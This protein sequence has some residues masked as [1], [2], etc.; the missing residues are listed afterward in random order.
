[1]T[2]K[3]SNVTCQWVPTQPTNERSKR[4][5][6]ATETQM[7]SGMEVYK[8]DGH[9]GFFYEVQD[10][11]SKYLRRPDELKNICFAQFAKMF[12]SKSSIEDEDANQ[13]DEY[14]DEV[15][16]E[17][18]TFMKFN[19]IMTFDEKKSPKQ[20]LPKMIKVNDAFPGEPRM[21][22]RRQFPAALRYISYNILD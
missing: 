18:Y 5:R 15:P 7:N 19:Y 11:Y 12:R 14:S 6:K 20:I 2:L 17:N 10:I 13:D 16:V 22:Q 8:L 4:H 3:S 1:M 9:D 21:M